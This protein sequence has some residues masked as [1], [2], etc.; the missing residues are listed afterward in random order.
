MNKKIINIIAIIL[1]IVCEITGLFLA[2]KYRDYIMKG[3]GYDAKVTE[4]NGNIATAECLIKTEVCERKGDPIS[5]TLEIPK[6]I[7]V[8][9]GDIIGFKYSKDYSLDTYTYYYTLPTD[10]FS[11]I[12]NI[13]TFLV[14]APIVSLFLF[15]FYS[16]IYKKK[17]SKISKYLPYLSAAM[18]FIGDFL[19]AITEIDIIQL[20]GFILL[21]GGII[22]PFLLKEKI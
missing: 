19:T 20:F 15:F 21:I 8:K 17:E 7:I 12:E 3:P 14:S 22:L 4:I 5:I 2:L 1:I 9:P 18:F 16:F 11:K 6:D 13:S 10:K